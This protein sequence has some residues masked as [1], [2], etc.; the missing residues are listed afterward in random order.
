M[1]SFLLGKN[2]NTLVNPLRVTSSSEVL[3][4][5]LL[6]NTGI[7]GVFEM[8]KSQSVVEDSDIA[9]TLVLSSNAKGES[10]DSESS[11]SDLHV[12]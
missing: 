7:E 6:E 1:G 4:V 8:L 10:R 11:S 12:D 5:E 3:L 9:W 2:L